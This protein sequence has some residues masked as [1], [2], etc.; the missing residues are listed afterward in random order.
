MTNPT[1][2]TDQRG[3][4][5]ETVLKIDRLYSAASQLRDRAADNP[6]RAD[7]ALRAAGRLQV[8]AY[9]LLIHALPQRELKRLTEII[10]ARYKRAA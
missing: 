6:S 8:R 2:P 1:N 7:L 3:L 4:T 5:A 10:A 9:T